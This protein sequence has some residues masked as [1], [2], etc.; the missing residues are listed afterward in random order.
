V[1]IVARNYDSRMRKWLD[2]MSGLVWTLAGT[3]LVLVTLSGSTRR[4]GLYISIAA[5]ALNLVLISL[6]EDNE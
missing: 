6:K 3:A 4:L 1:L 5:L 2:E